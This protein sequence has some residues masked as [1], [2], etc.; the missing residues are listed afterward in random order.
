[1]LD[2]LLNFF[3][4]ILI[5][6]GLLGILVVLMQKTSTQAGMGAAL[7]GGGAADQAF[8]AESATVLTKATQ[9]ITILFFVLAFLLYLGFQARHAAEL[10]AQEDAGLL[11]VVPP[12]EAPAPGAETEVTV[13]PEGA[14]G[15]D[16]EAATETE[17][18]GETEPQP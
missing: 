14:A 4:F 9:T 11:P 6:I 7:T 3:V 5:L 13:E 2:F 1:M 10:K 18:V 17:T 8:G 15:M 12:A 16:T